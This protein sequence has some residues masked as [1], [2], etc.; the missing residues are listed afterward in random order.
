MGLE[1]AV[2]DILGQARGE[3][4]AQLLGGTRQRVA[5][6]RAIV[7]KPK[8]FLFD[9][10]LSNLDAKLR[11]D[12]RAMLSRLHQRLETTFIY[13]THDQV[14]AMT[15]ADKIVVLRDMHF[16][17]AASRCLRDCESPYF[18][19]IDDDF[20]LHPKAIAYMRKRVLEYPHPEELGIYYCHLWED[21]TSRVRQ[22]IK[23][24]RMEALRQIG[25][26][27]VDRPQ[28]GRLR[29]HQWWWSR[30]QRGCPPS[31]EARSPDRGD[32]IPA[33]RPPRH[34]PRWRCPW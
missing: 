30:W 27:Q 9:E 29:P 5:V 14:E 12:A 33:R 11:V 26:F 17:E 24:Y 6:G 18:F 28:S 2:W 16:F 34:R 23:V 1:A 13:V 4:V 7:R 8:V 10:P 31:W 15:L 32:R 21:W 25:G 22:S 3:S 19:K 20:I